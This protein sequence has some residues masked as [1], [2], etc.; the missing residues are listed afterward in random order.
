MFQSE[1]ERVEKATPQENQL[2]CLDFVQ[3]VASA[4]PV[5]L[6]TFSSVATVA[7]RESGFEI[8]EGERECVQK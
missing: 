6:P 2:K 3:H 4:F 5:K 7:Q 8:K 1:G